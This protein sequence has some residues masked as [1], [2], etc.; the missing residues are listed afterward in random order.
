[1]WNGVGIH[2]LGLNVDVNNLALIE[3]VA[4]QEQRR[5]VRAQTIA[6]RLAKAGVSGALEG[7]R[8]Y[9]G[10]GAIGRPHF[11]KYL[12]ASGVVSNMN[13]AFKQYLGAGK[14]GDVKQL[15]PDINTAVNWIINAGGVAV[16]AHP[17]KYKLTR[18]KLRRLLSEF[19]EAGGQAIEV[20]S[21]KQTPNVTRDMAALADQLGLYASGGSDFHMPDQ[22]WQELG[23]VQFL[24]KNCRPVWQLWDKESSL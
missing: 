23:C 17:N 19:I 21:G 9:A 13:Q 22:P 6:D 5:I 14:V 16:V 24:P 7:A 10:E 2:I 1:L 18:T 20:I 4:Q 8:E 15:W 3:G 12:V 11:A